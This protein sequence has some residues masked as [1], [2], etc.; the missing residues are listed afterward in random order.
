LSQTTDPMPGNL[1]EQWFERL[2]TFLRFG[3]GL[4]AINDF[5]PTPMPHDEAQG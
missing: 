1:Y 4:I 2:P 3:V 5:N